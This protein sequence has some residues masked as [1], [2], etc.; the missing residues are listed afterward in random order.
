MLLSRGFFVCFFTEVGPKCCQSRHHDACR[1]VTVA[2]PLVCDACSPCLG[3]IG[4]NGGTGS[5]ASARKSRPLLKVSHLLRF[6]Q[7]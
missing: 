6:L 5:V 3:D 2:F 4:G 1:D 7:N